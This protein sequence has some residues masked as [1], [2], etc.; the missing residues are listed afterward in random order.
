ME[1]RTYQQWLIGTI[2][3]VIDYY[4]TTKVG[5][6]YLF[7]SYLATVTYSY[8]V[9]SR[10]GLW[11][12]I[13]TP[14]F[15]MSALSTHYKLWQ[16]IRYAV[17]KDMISFIIGLSLAVYLVLLPELI[18][19]ILTAYGITKQIRQV[20]NNGLEQILGNVA[21]MFNRVAQPN[22]AAPARGQVAPQP[23]QE[24]ANFV[25]QLVS[26]FSA[27][28]GEDYDAEERSQEDIVKKTLAKVDD[29]D[30]EV[31]KRMAGEDDSGSSEESIV[32]GD[33]DNIETPAPIEQKKEV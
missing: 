5:V 7:L 15:G 9:A 27:I 31:L 19:Y 24:G 23:Q 26:A 22:G 12:A 18:K 14:L 8:Y 32:E 30:N 6:N 10:Y 21:T 11:A 13:N 29:D 17:A 33:I 2:A 1:N 16:V 3:L 20:Q 4:V 25:N 28:N